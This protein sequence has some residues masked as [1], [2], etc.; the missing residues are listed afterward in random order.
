MIKSIG[1][2]V[3]SVDY[4]FSGKLTGFFYASGSGLCLILFKDG[5]Q[6]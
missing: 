3:W 5:K 6:Y 2:K 4:K 1:G